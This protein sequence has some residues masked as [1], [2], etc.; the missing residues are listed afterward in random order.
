MATRNEL[1]PSKWLSAADVDTPVVATIERCTIETVG[2]GNRAERKPVV[3]F[4]GATKPLILNRTNF[5]AVATISGCE[6]TDDWAGTPLELYAIDTTGPSG[7]TRGVRV[8]APRKSAKPRRPVRD[9]VDEA[10]PT[11]EPEPAL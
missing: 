5:D 1:Y 2:S 9:D 8:R 7:P 3:Y 10:V 4:G 6:D 11:I